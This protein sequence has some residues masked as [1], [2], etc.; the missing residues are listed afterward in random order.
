MA[1]I[2]LDM[3][4]VICD[5]M[6]DWHRRYNEDYQDTLTVEKLKCW[7]SENYVK[8][9]CGLK[10]YD[11]LREP[12]LFLHLK[13]LPHAIEV[14]ERLS[15]QHEI[16]IVT[17]S[18]STAFTE[19]EMWVEEHLHFIGKENII[20]THK[21]DKVCGDLLFDDAPH[22]LEAFQSTGRIAVAMNYP[23][24]QKLEIPRVSNWLEFER[25]IMEN[26]WGLKL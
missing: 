23:Y 7:K 17:S 21:K 1:T 2:L 13:A 5:L 20:F 18:V 3:D 15:Q 22:N 10:I 25:G 4:S 19:K 12:G 24:N 14:I 8:P 26:W 16:M 9:E 11:Y 6:T